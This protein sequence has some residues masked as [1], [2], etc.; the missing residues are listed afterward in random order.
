VALDTTLAARRACLGH[1]AVWTLSGSQCQRALL[2]GLVT[3]SLLL[4]LTV[5]EGGST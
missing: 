2:P 1:V 3:M 4:A 5:A